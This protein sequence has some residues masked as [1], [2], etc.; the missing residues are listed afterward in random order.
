MH[1][2]PFTPTQNSG[3]L[4]AC[5]GQQFAFVQL[6]TVLSVLFSTFELTLATPDG[7]VP[8]PNYHAMVVGPKAPCTVK[9]RRRKPVAV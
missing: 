1:Q 8:P 3:G 7:A 5:L 2:P 9:F 6:K 4:H